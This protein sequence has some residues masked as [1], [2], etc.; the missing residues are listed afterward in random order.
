NIRTEHEDGFVVDAGP[1]SFVITKPD[2]LA[3]CRELG[4]EQEL[5]A[6]EDEARHV[7]FAHGGGLEL[8]PGGMA[9][10][11]PTRIGPLLKTPLVSLPGRLRMLL[12]PFIP[13]RRAS[14]DESLD[15]F[16]T[17]RLGA[18]GARALARPLLR[19]SYAA[20]IAC[21]GIDGTFPQLV[22]LEQKYGSL[23]RGFLA[24]E[25][26]RGGARAERPSVAAVLRWLRR[27]GVA[28]AAS[29]FRAMKRG[30]GSLI[31]TLA[32]FLPTG[33]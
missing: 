16:L 11:V 28:Q 18:A 10:A 2:A 19:G 8:M 14:G 20:G 22:E 33:A 3:L 15:A 24:L 31:E 25:L 26:S 29:P 21:L 13:P 4:I 17:R 6:T 27:P 32:G 7:F 12:E 9:L 5:C 1:D 23:V 30:M